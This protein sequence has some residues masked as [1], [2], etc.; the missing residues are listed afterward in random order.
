VIAAPPVDPDSARRAARDIVRSRGY[1]PE[2]VPRPLEGVLRWIG[3][4]LAPVGELFGD[5][6]G[7]IGDF[8]TH[9]FGLVLLIAMVAGV[10][11]GVAALA[12]RRRGAPAVTAV[13][14]GRATEAADDPEALEAAATAAEAA[15]AFDRAVRLRFR[16]GLLRLDRAGAIQLRPSLTSGQ[17]SGSLAIP[18]LDELART[19][20]GIAY[21][22]RD[23]APPDAAAARA[24]WPRVLDEA[25]HR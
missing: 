25:G 13:T 18:E 16:A 3:D 12:I 15:G 14:A 24:G 11:A 22:G 8:L 6:F 23:A 2:R 10:A 5:V 19:F 9:G 1:Q 17:V 7:A 21:G 4:R 20:E